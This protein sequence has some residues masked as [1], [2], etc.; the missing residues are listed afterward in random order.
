MWEY[1]EGGGE[2]CSAVQGWLL[3]SVH[4][5]GRGRRG[6]DGVNGVNTPASFVFVEG[7]FCDCW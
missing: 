3:Y 2:G 1:N 7:L 6:V 4:W 5:G